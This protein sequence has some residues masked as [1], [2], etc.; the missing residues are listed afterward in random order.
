MAL[1]VVPDDGDGQEMVRCMRV[2]EVVVVGSHGQHDDRGGDHGG[3]RPAARPTPMDAT[4]KVT[5]I[6]FY[7]TPQTKKSPPNPN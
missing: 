6:I 3:D 7:P 5:Y 4:P 1:V 2:R